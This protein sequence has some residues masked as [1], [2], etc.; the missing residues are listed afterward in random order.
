MQPTFPDYSVIICNFGGR[1]N[2]IQLMNKEKLRK[3]G[4]IMSIILLIVSSISFFVCEDKLF[5]VLYLAIGVIYLII[6]LMPTTK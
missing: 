3:I 2:I 1:F 4:L 6:N 5:P